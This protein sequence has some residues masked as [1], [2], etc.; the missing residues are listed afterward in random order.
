MSKIKHLFQNIDKKFKEDSQQDD[1]D[2]PMVSLN[3]RNRFANKTT[4]LNTTNDTNLHIIDG[5][6]LLLQSVT[7]YFYNNDAIFKVIEI[8]SGK[9]DISLRDIEWT[10]TNYTKKNDVYYFIDDRLFIVHHKYKALLKGYHTSKCETFQRGRRVRFYYN[11]KDYFITTVGQMCF[12]KWLIQ[13]KVLDYI[14]KNLEK[15][16]EDMRISHK[17]VKEEKTKTK[18]NKRRELSKSASNKCVIRNIKVRIEF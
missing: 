7:K 15:I 2:I 14:E 13:N 3:D 9:S 1:S 11:E 17:T 10:V 4:S 5:K 18:N 8:I 16:K 12:F 6:E